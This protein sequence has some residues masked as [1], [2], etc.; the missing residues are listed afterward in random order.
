MGNNY[1]A[2]VTKR[3]SRKKVIRDID[4]YDR[5]EITG[6]AGG[7]KGEIYRLKGATVLGSTGTVTLTVS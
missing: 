5:Y 1:A 2:A 4:L 6:G 3:K 7:L